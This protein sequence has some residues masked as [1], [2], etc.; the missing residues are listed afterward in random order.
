MF[1][2]SKIG[3]I[4]GCKKYRGYL[5]YRRELTRGVHT[6]EMRRTGGNEKPRFYDLGFDRVADC[7]RKGRFHPVCRA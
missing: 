5:R 6:P 2:T 7:A 3:N 1:L 4:P